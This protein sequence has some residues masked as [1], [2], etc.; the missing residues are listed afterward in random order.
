MSDVRSI[1]IEGSAGPEQTLSYIHLPF[2]VPEGTTRVEVAYSYSDAIGSDPQLTGGN[3]VDLG[4]F[5]ARGIEFPGAG[6]RGWSGSARSQ[7][8][9][10]L[11]R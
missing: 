10:C 11:S 4:I 3:T 7:A 8:R 2:E 9:R 1:V 6:F 5:D